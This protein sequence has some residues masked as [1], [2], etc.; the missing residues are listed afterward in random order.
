M[1]E[2][3]DSRRTRGC[4]YRLPC[5][6]WGFCGR[7][8]PVRDLAGRENSRKRRFESSKVGWARAMKRIYAFLITAGLDSVV[9]ALYLTTAGASPVAGTATVTGTVD[10]PKSFKAAQVYYRNRSKRML[11]M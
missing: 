7:Q 3:H 6:V 1:E 10:A 8:W 9:A 11:Y 2:R 5:E 4:R